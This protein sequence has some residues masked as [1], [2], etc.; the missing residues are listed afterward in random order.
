MR[1]RILLE[2]S[3]DEHK[4]LHLASADQGKLELVRYMPESHIQCSLMRSKVILITKV[5]KV[6]K[7]CCHLAQG[8]I[9]E[10]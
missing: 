1:C 7:F 2:L 9:E 6:V 5:E 3:Q 10:N 4:L 8:R